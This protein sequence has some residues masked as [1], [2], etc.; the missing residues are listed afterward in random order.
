MRI[1]VAVLATLM[2]APQ[3]LVGSL[4]AADV[5]YDYSLTELPYPGTY[6]C[7]SRNGQTVTLAG[8]SRVVTAIEILLSSGGVSTFFV[9]FYNLDGPNGVPDSLIW[10]SGIQT[11]PFVPGSYNRQI[12]DVPV[13]SVLVPNSFAWTI[14]NIHRENDALPISRLPTIGTASNS[15]YFEFGEWVNFDPT[16]NFGARIHAVPE[17]SH[18]AFTALVALIVC[19][20]K[21]RGSGA[22]EPAQKLPRLYKKSL[23]VGTSCAKPWHP[24]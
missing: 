9:E 4:A 10:Q 14:S 2:V 12:V 23:A 13:P 11:Y 20:R 7:C 15:W 17:S 19:H 8:T 21:R 18:F 3:L 22:V 24:V 5:V 16:V 1:T 6:G